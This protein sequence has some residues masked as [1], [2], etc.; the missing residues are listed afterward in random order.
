MRVP[1]TIMCAQLRVIDW[2]GSCAED[3][4]SGIGDRAGEPGV[5]WLASIARW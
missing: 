3:P 2:Y 1:R 4:L 5:R